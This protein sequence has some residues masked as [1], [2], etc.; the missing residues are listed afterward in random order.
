MDAYKWKNTRVLGRGR[1]LNEY[2]LFYG[3]PSS[4]IF[5]FSSEIRLKG[6]E[7]P[8]VRFDL[9]LNNT[10][11]LEMEYSCSL[12]RLECQSYCGN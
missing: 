3:E 1:D 11:Y 8:H 6:G 4:E 9:C 12:M 2:E 10:Y 7:Q 5:F